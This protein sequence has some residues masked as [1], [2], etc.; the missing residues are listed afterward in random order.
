VIAG[1]LSTVAAVLVLMRL[2]PDVKHEGE[3]GAVSRTSLSGGELLWK[4]KTSCFGTFAYGYFQSSIVLFMP[5]YLIEVKGIEERATVAL[6]GFFALGMLTFANF[7]GR[8]GDRH[9]HLLLMRL[10]GI[11]GCGVVASFVY[12]NHYWLMAAFVCAA[13]V[14]LASIS[15]ISLALQGVIVEPPDYRRSNAIYN[16]FYAAGML[17]GPLISSRIFERAGGGMMMTHLAGL[18]AVFVA[19]TIVFAAD[20]PAYVAKKAAKA[21]VSQ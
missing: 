5:L 9:G 12:V 17:V 13:G 4:I 11:A 16:V 8:L 6:F 10:L 20:D 1:I 2:D 21:P 3:G 14:T 19:F 18:W 7:A 15:P